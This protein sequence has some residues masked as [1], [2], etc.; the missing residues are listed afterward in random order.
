MFSTNK[1]NKEDQ[2]LIK[3]KLYKSDGLKSSFISSVR[4][5]AKSY[6]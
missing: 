5:R 1:Y 2:N 6:I 4:F 3:K